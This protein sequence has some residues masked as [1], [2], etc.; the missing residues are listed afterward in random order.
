MFCGDSPFREEALFIRGGYRNH[1]GV[2]GILTI[3]KSSIKGGVI[4]ISHENRG[5]DTRVASIK[6]TF[7]TQ[8]MCL[9]AQ[10]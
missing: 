5:R 7:E 1:G 8:M 6:C 3:F 10:L 2:I 4:G 9:E